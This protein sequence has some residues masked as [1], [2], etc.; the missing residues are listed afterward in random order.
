[1]KCLICDGTGNNLLLD[2]CCTCDGTGERPLGTDGAGI[3]C[4]Q[5]NGDGLVDEGTVEG[6][7]QIADLT[8]KVND[9]SDKLDDIIEKLNE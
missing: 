6:A 3:E 4:D 2:I 7:E 9:N 1:M 8:D 5:C